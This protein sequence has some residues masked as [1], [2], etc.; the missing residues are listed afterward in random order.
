MLKSIGDGVSITPPSTLRLFL[1]RCLGILFNSAGDTV[2]M[3]MLRFKFPYE[4]EWAR[5]F[6]NPEPEAPSPYCPIK[7]SEPR[8][9]LRGPSAGNTGDVNGVKKSLAGDRGAD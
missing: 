9:P 4:S 7:G 8:F 6:L 1:L 5:R 2:A 3:F